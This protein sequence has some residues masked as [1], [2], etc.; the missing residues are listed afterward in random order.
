MYELAD[1]FWLGLLLLAC[2]Y[3]WKAHGMKETALAAVRRYCRE[4]Q[5]DL[6]DDTV[7]LK[8]FWF[9]RDSQGRIRM[10]RTFLFEFSSTGEERYS[11]R[12][13]LLGS[14]VESIQLQPYR[15]E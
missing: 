1:I 2:F 11:G 5:L 8:A 15:F 3:W 14:T 9:K 10:W 7:V 13:V 4:M 6:L 12:I